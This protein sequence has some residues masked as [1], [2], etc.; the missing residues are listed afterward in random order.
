MGGPMA[1][2]GRVD[3]GERRQAALDLLTQYIR[4]VDDPRRIEEWPALF[5]DDAEYIVITRENHERN[6]PIAVIRDD[7]K[8][9]IADRVTIIREF[10][11]AGGRAADRHY[12]DAWPRHVVGPVW[13]EFSESGDALVGANFAVYQSVQVDVA[14]R[15]LAVG[16]YKD[17]VEFSGATATYKAKKVILDTSVLQ[18]VFVYPL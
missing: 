8:D 9:R 15:L 11:G 17:V 10:W 18:D 6:L 7:S 4:I 16:E 2:A 13:V 5:S 1:L 12:N 3:L 14:P